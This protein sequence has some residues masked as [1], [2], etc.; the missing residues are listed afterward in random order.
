MTTTP[1]GIHSYGIWCSTSHAWPA[2][3]WLKT[4]S[5]GGPTPRSFESAED[6]QAWIDAA[7][8]KFDHVKYEPR[9]LT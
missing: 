2:T 8:L 4:F 9:R 6:A 7:Q 3:G 5:G 1:L